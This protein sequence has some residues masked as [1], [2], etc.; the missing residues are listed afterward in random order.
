L[1]ANVPQQTA[2]PNCQEAGVLGVV[3]GTIGL[4]M[5]TEAIR[6]LTGLG[7][8]PSVSRLMHYNALKPSL[9][10]WSLEPDPQCPLCGTPATITRLGQALPSASV[11][12]SPDVPSV[13]PDAA[14]QII[15]QGGKWLD[16]RE[17]DAFLEG[18]LP[19]AVS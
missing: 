13:F 1:F 10:T 14:W 6:L 4:F 8:S 16:V 7:D 9:S 5:A 17:A 11:C 3:P 18:H 19:D 12:L 15:H 2:L